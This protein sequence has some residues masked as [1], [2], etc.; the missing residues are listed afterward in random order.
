MKFMA[1]GY[2]LASFTCPHCEATTGQD[3]LG[4]G[5]YPNSANDYGTAL[6]TCQ[7]LDC[8]RIAHWVGEVVL[9]STAGGQVYEL[10]N[11][12][13]VWPP[14]RKGPEP[15]PDLAADVQKDYQEARAVF[16]TSPRAAAALLRLALQKLMV[17][18]NLMGKNLNDDIGTLVADGLSSKIQQAL[19]IVRVTGNDA[20]HPGQIDTDNPDTVFKLFGLINVIAHDRITQPAE[21]DAMYADLPQQ[22]LDGI[23]QRDATT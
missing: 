11:V 16:D 14:L 13:M 20:V 21:I 4:P 5:I 15:N 1:P 17:Q 22:K 7:S 6:S 19:D 9:T 18:L 3:W 12:S 2:Q 8:K 23:A 10:E